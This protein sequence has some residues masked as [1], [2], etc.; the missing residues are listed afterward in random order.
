MENT[1]AFNFSRVIE[2]AKSVITDPVSFYRKLSKTGGFVEPLIFVVVMAAIAALIMLI[3][4]FV[5]GRPVGVGVLIVMP[6]I[7]AIA[8]FISAGILFLIWKL[9]G[10]ENNY[11]TAYRCVAYSMAILP[12]SSLLS[13]IPFIG[14][15]VPV[16]WGAFFMITAST[17]VHSLDKQ[18]A[19]IVFGV[20]AFIGVIVNLG[21]ERAAKNMEEKMGMFE[22]QVGKGMKGMEDMTPEEMGKAAG[23]FLRGLEDATREGQ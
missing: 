1:N 12:I 10:S 17:E 22:Q 23:E 6:I 2:D 3:F 11:E 9:M 19:M 20:L 5:G 13:I 18:K 8:S 21:S 16:L 15:V 14:Q 4:S 7:M